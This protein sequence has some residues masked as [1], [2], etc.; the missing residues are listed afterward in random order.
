MIGSVYWCRSFPR[1]L[2]F[3]YQRDSSRVALKLVRAGG[4]TG[5]VW[6]IAAK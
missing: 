5:G 2:V 3:E 1:V 4:S 6:F